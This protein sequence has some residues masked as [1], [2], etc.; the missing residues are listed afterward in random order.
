MQINIEIDWIFNCWFLYPQIGWYQ[1]VNKPGL[2]DFRI[3]VSNRAA[4]QPV[5]VERVIQVRN[6][7]AIIRDA[8]RDWSN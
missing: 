1:K 6:V 7:G 5:T 4:G 8:P 3:L 2:A